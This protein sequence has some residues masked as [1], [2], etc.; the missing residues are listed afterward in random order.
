MDTVKDHV[1]EGKQHSIYRSSIIRDVLALHGTEA[2]CSEYPFQVK[3]MDEPGLDF[4]GV[5]RDMYCAFWASAYE[6]HFD[7]SNVLVPLMQAGMEQTTF[8]QFGRVLAHGFLTC[9][10]LPIRIAF[11]TLACSLISTSV[12]ISDRILLTTFLDFLAPYEGEIISEALTEADHPDVKDFSQ[13]SA[14]ESI[15]GRFGARKLPSKGNLR[16][17]I[18]DIA[19][20]L[21]VIQPLPACHLMHSGIPPKHVEFWSSLTTDELYAMYQGMAVSAKRIANSF[22]EPS[23]YSNPNEERVY[24]YLLQCI[25][26]LPQEE[27]SLFLRFVTGSSVFC[28]WPI[29]ITFNGLTG[30]A[31]RPIAHC[32]TCMLELSSAYESFFEF[33]KEMKTVLAEQSS[34]VMN[35][36]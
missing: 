27:L 2:A 1:R 23:T 13:K 22:V 31:R 15:L 16:N 12:A 21:F 25:G 3:F 29:Y 14:V 24:G 5:T 9:Q 11:P 8:V 32:C 19:E 17:L 10:M 35:A 7:G 6:S 36:V 4:G 18:R 26:N 28:N 20:L 34:F 33:N 30:L